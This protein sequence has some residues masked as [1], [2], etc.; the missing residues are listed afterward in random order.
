MQLQYIQPVETLPKIY[1][2]RTCFTYVFCVSYSTV[3][4]SDPAFCAEGFLVHLLQM[5]QRGSSYICY[6]WNRGVPRTFATHE[7]STRKLIIQID[8]QSTLFL[9]LSWQTF[10]LSRKWGDFLDLYFQWIFCLKKI[11][12]FK[13]C[14]WISN[15]KVKQAKTNLPKYFLLFSLNQLIYA[16]VQCREPKKVSKRFQF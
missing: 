14:S 12:E 7:I 6:T 15:Y 16:H 13:V 10:P 3:L 2:N 1:K 9:L 5:K 11:M 4:H 8:E